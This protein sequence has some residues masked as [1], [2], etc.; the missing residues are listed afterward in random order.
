MCERGSANAS[1]STSRRWKWMILWIVASRAVSHDL[2]ALAIAKAQLQ[3]V[4]VQRRIKVVAVG[5]VAG[6]VLD[7]CHDATIEF[8]VVVDRNCQHFNVVALADLVA[9]VEVDQGLFEDFSCDP[10]CV[11][12][13]NEQAVVSQSGT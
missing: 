13:E 12:A 3:H 2:P 7:P 6:L 11:A 5:P 8:D 10:N 1:V 4:E 9:G